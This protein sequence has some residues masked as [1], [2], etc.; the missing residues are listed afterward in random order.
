M[1]LL[2]ALMVALLV[3]TVIWTALTDPPPHWPPEPDHRDFDVRRRGS[4]A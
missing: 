4:D 2:L 3:G 1:M